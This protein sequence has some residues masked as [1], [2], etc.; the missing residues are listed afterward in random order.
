MKTIKYTFGL[1]LSLITIASISSCSE[2]SVYTPGEEA[3]VEVSEYY[4]AD[5][6]ETA[7]T[8]GV[9]DKEI[10]AVI[11][12][13]NAEEAATLDLIVTN[14][15]DT[16][17]TIPE[18]VTFEAGATSAELKIQVNDAIEFF[19][20]YK[21]V[22]EIPEEFTNPYIVE[23]NNPKLDFVVMRDDYVPYAY[24][25]YQSWF[26][27]QEW[28]AVL[29]YSEF[30]GL[31]RFKDCW[32]PGYDVTFEWDGASE[33]FTMSEGAY[34]SGYIY[35]PYGMLNAEVYNKGAINS[36]D[37]EAKIFKF[38]YTWKVSAGSLGA[39]YDYFIITDLAE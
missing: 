18:T 10:V 22:V 38:A 39:G 37:P 11:N 5:G 24:G 19:T 35:G 13:A 6:T 33:T 28:D 34:A 32:M 23:N 21:F 2:E 25:V 9:N 1:L 7:L 17:F 31:Y 8:I 30:L 20:N 12:R 4:F 29:E 15:N 14:P 26:F 16:L 36:Y 27:E 3:A